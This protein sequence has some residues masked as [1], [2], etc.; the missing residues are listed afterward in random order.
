MPIFPEEIILPRV[1][2]TWHDSGLAVIGNWMGLVYQITHT[3]RKLPFMDGL[4][5]QN[6]LDL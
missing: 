1:Q 5:S 6:P 2:N 3:D 4:D